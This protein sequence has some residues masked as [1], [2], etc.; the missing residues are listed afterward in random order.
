MFMTE[1]EYNVFTQ[2]TPIVSAVVNLTD[3]CNLR[4]PYCFTEHNT[5]KI[6]LD[7][8]KKVVFFLIQ[9]EQKT[10]RIEGKTIAFFGGEPMLMFE[11]IIRPF[12]E[13]MEKEDLIEKHNFSFS[14]T[15]NGTLFTE[16][17]LK[18][19]KKYKCNILLSMD[20]DKETQDDQRPGV[21]GKSSFDMIINNLPILLKY[22]PNIC[23]R[24]T[25]E[26]RNVEKVFDN[27]LFA[28]KLGFNRI[29]FAPNQ[30][31]G[32][33]DQTAVIYER[34]IVK[35]VLQMYMDIKN[36]VPP[37]YL[38]NFISFSQ[39]MFPDI[40]Y[41]NVK[42]R[43]PKDAK[44][45]RTIYRCGLGTIGIGVACDGTINGCQE[46]NTFLDDDIFKIGNLDQGIDRSKHLRLINCYLE[47]NY[48]NDQEEKYCK[49]CPS[50]ESCT[51]K[52]CPS[53]DIS[54]DGLKR[55]RSLITCRLNEIYQNLC[56]FII[57]LMDKEEDPQVIKELD[58]LF[59]S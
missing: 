6:S 12:F 39:R 44:L 47:D 10:K 28:R 33:T 31:G 3:N 52:G 27:Y 32:W 16:E 45:F 25:V 38:D 46:R 4:C 49:T 21:N 18:F 13:W 14:M 48:I 36:K 24:A 30:D 54:K 50:F 42:D 7:I 43:F 58:K 11:E 9:E 1:E 35:C 15:S 40:H 55:N 5:R 59:I 22:Y 19:L 23:F 51:K 20:G 41:E 53:H 37:L 34:E 29:F 8:L 56:Y 57:H 17:R 26:P 2:T